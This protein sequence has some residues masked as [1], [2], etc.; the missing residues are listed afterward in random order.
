MEAVNVGTPRAIERS[1]GTVETS[2]IW[3]SPVEGR[4]PLR[5][6]NFDGDDQAD[7]RVHGGPD[8]AVYA[9]AIEDTEFWEAELERMLGP[10]AF[11]ENLTVRGL[12]LNRAL[13]G[14]RWAVGSALLEVTAPRIPCWKLA[15]KMED[16]FFIKRFAAAGRP[17]V[18]LRILEEGDIGAGDEIEIVA[19]PTEHEVTIALMNQVLL[20]D[21]QDAELL[22]PA[23]I[24]ARVR[25]WAEEI[26][27]YSSTK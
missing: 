2:A 23:P 27:A 26:A 4:V 7:R 12:D 25:A 13:V 11:G 6:V 17:G 16:P 5:G 1:N 14:E 9:Y 24:P 21:H 15:K 3:K 18:Y 10:G 20:F 19:R 8:Q 22:L